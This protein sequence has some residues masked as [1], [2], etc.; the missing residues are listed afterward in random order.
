MTPENESM[1]LAG[2]DHESFDQMDKAL[3]FIGYSVNLA[4]GD[5]EVLPLLKNSRYRT[6]AVLL[7]LKSPGGRGLDTL[8]TIRQS[9][10]DLPIIVVSE[11][12]SAQGIVAAMKSG[13]SD[14]L[15]K[16]VNVE[17]LRVSIVHSLDRKRA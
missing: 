9:S 14:F 10:L 12:S 17:E 15:S 7:A 5:S 1:V 11:T 6:V 16:P 13:A 2:D 8:R 4:R 3:R